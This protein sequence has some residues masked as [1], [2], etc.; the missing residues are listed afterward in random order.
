MVAYVLG[1]LHPEHCAAVHSNITICLPSMS[2]P[3]T[4]LQVGLLVASHL[5]CKEARSCNASE[6][7]CSSLPPGPSHAAFPG[8]AL[9][10]LCTVQ[11]TTYAVE[12]EQAAAQQESILM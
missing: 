10:T 9:F 2:N 3:W 11:G 12:A 5:H 8:T 6:Q 7:C 4:M 1:A